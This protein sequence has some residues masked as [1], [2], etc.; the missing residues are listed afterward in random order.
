[1]LYMNILF[2]GEAFQPLYLLMGMRLSRIESKISY[3][4]NAL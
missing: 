3:Q 2:D 4:C 1:M